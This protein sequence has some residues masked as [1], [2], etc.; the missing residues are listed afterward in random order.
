MSIRVVLVDDHA[1]VRDGIKSIIERKSDDIE[2]I[3]EAA[4]G[5][6]ALQLAQKEKPDIYIVDISLPII[7]GL[8][9]TAR[10]KKLFLSRRSLS[11]ACMTNTPWWKRH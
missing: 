8:D 6:A 2:I 10:L 3:G 7:N 5:E 4:N 1:I 11:S 9:L